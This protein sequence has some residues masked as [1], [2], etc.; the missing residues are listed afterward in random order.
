MLASNVEPPRKLGW[1]W[2]HDE[3]HPAC[4]V[5]DAIS[6][7][8]EG[9]A[10]RT[11][12]TRRQDDEIWLDVRCNIEDHIRWPARARVNLNPRIGAQALGQP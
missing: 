7:A 9:P 12:I 10:D 5:H 3:D 11:M 4:L 6:R 8:P 1:I 2:R